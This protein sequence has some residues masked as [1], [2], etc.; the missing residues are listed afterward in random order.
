LAEAT[1]FI[2]LVIL[3][4]ERT[5]EILSFISLSAAIGL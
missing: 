2:A 4:V 5:E 3:S 1:S